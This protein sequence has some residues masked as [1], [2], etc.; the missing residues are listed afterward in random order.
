MGTLKWEVDKN[1]KTFKVPI[2]KEF[3][4]FIL[5][6]NVEIDGLV[7]EIDHEH[8]TAHVVDSSTECE[9]CLI[10]DFIQYESQKYKVT[11][12]CNYSFSTQKHTLKIKR[13]QIPSSI[14]VI[15][16]DWLSTDDASSIC[17]IISP[18]NKNFILF[19]EKIL[20]GKS[21]KDDTEYDT[22]LHIKSTN[23]QI[24]IPSFIKN[25]NVAKCALRNIRN[26]TFN[27][28]SKIKVF[29][30]NLFCS[31][32]INS[33]VIPAS[34]IV[35][36]KDT[37]YQSTL[38]TV[39]FA[40]DSNLNLIEES[41]F[42]NS[43]IS[44]IQIPL[45][46]KCIGP[47][48]FKDCKNLNK[49]IFLGSE[50][51][52]I[53]KFAFTG[54]PIVSFRF[55]PKIT[56]IE[57]GAFY[58]CSN[59]ESVEFS[60]DSLQMIDKYAFSM[61]SIKNIKIP[62]SV[63]EIRERAFYKCQKLISIQ[64]DSDSKLRLFSNKALQYSSIKSLTIPFGLE[65]FQKDWCK[66]TPNLTNIQ[67]TNSFKNCSKNEAVLFN[68]N[69]LFF[70]E[71][72]NNNDV[73]IPFYIK[74]ISDSAFAN[75]SQIS[76]VNFESISK[77]V[78]I[79]SY[80]FN[81]SSI[82]SICI[83]KSV[84]EIDKKAFYECK[85]LKYVQFDKNSELKT[86]NKKAFAKTLIKT[87][88]LPKSVIKI[89]DKAF[90]YTNLKYITF[91]DDSELKYIGKNVFNN[92]FI[93]EFFVPSS[94]V[95]LDEYSLSTMYLK[96]LVFR[97]DSQLESMNNAISH[98]SIKY[99]SIPKNIKSCSLHNTNLR[100]VEFLGDDL[101]MNFWDFLKSYSISMISFPNANNV[102]IDGLCHIEF[103]HSQCAIFCIPFALKDIDGNVY[104][105]FIKKVY[106]VQS[107][108]ESES[109]EDEILGSNI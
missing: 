102:I 92:T 70:V 98:S 55:P 14:E 79:C 66:N 84:V 62:S 27:A 56:K 5:L 33:V 104:T 109:D 41:A 1:S 43:R 93:E 75:C 49:I 71:R 19:D 12:I 23:N 73:N 108:S 32:L 74:E 31:S 97:P 83:P 3:I 28:D 36:Q 65:V 72:N 18:K 52:E 42:E 59:L 53:K 2:L 67:L 80:S 15:E 26:I 90:S 16:K 85:Q 6:M 82:T 30:R 4:L 9:D 103:I 69:K 40:P 7:Y 105:K 17:V 35:I 107:E 20:I 24:T 51:T 96:S 22:I 34:V 8:K 100:S 44:L 91:P 94:V 11:K 57:N 99:I 25:F 95:Q 77:L 39:S 88:E 81:N 38:K 89:D 45:K 21:K 29:P 106:L 47:Y 50:L 37:F 13:I 101:K 87:I 78:R 63:L 76:N 86:I 58:R 64:F 48:A 60:S 68:D 54:C 46:V 10:P 61:T